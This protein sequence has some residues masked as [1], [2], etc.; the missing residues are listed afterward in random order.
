ME[1]LDCDLLLVH[2]ER[3]TYILADV[4]CRLKTLDIC[5]E[6]LDNPKISDTMMSIAEMVTTN[7]QTLSMD[8]PH[9][10]QKKDLHCRK[11]AAQ[12]HCINKNTFNPVMTSP[13]YL[14][15]KTTICAWTKIWC[16]HSTTFCSTNN[17]LSF[18]IQ[19]G[20]KVHFIHLRQ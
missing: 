20:I 6:L 9:A 19:K 16:Y 1:L 7:R 2:I 4:I 17:P 11:L 14:L 10:K 13:D 15:Q 3:S 5:K 18:I 8:K 12:S